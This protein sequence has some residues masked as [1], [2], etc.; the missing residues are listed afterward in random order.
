MQDAAQ[1]IPRERTLNGASLADAEEGQGRD[2]RMCTCLR[3]VM[4]KGNFPRLRPSWLA[5]YDLVSQLRAQRCL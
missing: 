1:G 3:L 5:F 2:G 4:K